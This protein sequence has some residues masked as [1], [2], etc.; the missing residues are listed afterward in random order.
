M[1]SPAY[2]LARC[3]VCAGA[4]T[5]EIADQDAV[6]RE[7]EWLW[8]FHMRRLRPHTPPQS[9]T[10]RVAFSQSPAYRIVQCIGCGLV[11]RNP[12]ER[13]HEV[14][15]AYAGEAP[16]EDVMAALFDTQRAGY[17]A[18]AARLTRIAG[19]SGSGLEVGSYVGGFLSAARDRGWRFEGVDVNPDACAF[20]RRRGFTVTTGDI[21]A[22][23]STRQFNAV[24]IWNCL[25][26]LADPR[27]TLVAARRLI[28]PGGTLAVRVPNGGV[29]A[30]LRPWLER[31]AT[32]ASARAVLAHNNLLGFPYRWGFTIASLSRLLALAGFRVVR[33]VGDTLVPIADEHTRW[34][35]AV[36]E[37]LLK[38]VMR[39]AVGRAAPSAPW[40]EIYARP[41][42]A[43]T[44]G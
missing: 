43:G 41:S 15:A 26:Q 5:R 2:E 25:D 32:A 40:F 35:A 31:G 10:D 21:G 36:E 12:R 23:P 8:E 38:G 30:A 4:D 27:A 37:R 6:K 11:H 17:R 39:A 1:R 16:G 7:I 44:P 18:Q 28:A 3:P 24:A 20:V 34:W 13:E 33:T 14:N 42:D 19:R 29:Y 22:V 9:L